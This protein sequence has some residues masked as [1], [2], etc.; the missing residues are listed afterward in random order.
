MS[1]ALSAIE[2]KIQKLIAHEQSAREIGSLNEANA[3]AEKI[4]GLC[5][6]YGIEVA[7]LSQVGGQKVSIVHREDLTYRQMGFTYKH[8]PMY[9]HS[10]FNVVALGNNCRAIRY[11][12]SD[13]ITL[14]GHDKD[15]AVTKELFKQLLRTA[16]R[17]AT[18]HH[19]GSFVNAFCITV[20]QR[21]ESARIARDRQYSGESTAL[22]RVYRDDVDKAFREMFPNISRT[23]PKVNWDRDSYRAGVRAGNKVSLNTNQMGQGVGRKQLGS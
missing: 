2:I 7:R 16:L 18:G 22:V 10:L 12:G 4:V 11:P 9:V 5:E 19:K 23:T 21:L 17:Y 20:N 3:F 1:E 6:E 8:P 15:R 14:V 13:R